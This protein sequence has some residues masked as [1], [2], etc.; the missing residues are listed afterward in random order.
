MTEAKE[1]GSSAAE[2]VRKINEDAGTPC[3][4]FLVI[5]GICGSNSEFRLNAFCPRYCLQKRREEVSHGGHGGFFGIGSGWVTVF[6]NTGLSTGRHSHER[7]AK[8]H[9]DEVLPKDTTGRSI[10][11]KNLRALRV[12]CTSSSSDPEA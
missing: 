12:L 3:A 4:L 5:C 10:H 8:P 2:S 11:F 6:A 1:L 7:P 9:R